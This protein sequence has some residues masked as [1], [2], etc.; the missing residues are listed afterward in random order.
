MT[1]FSNYSIQLSSIQPIAIFLLIA[2][3]VAWYLTVLQ[4]QMMGNM[5]GTMG[6]TLASYI[7]MWTLM[8]AAMML[9]SITPLATRYYR[10]IRS[11][12]L[13]GSLSFAAGY[14][15]IWA[16]TGILAFF[17]AWF[18]GKVL[19]LESAVQMFIAAAIFT[20]CGIYQFSN[21]KNTCLKVCRAPFSLLLKYASWRGPFRHFRVGLHHGI[22]CFSCCFFLMALMFVFGVMNIAAMLVLTIV[23]ALEKHI[24]EE[25]ILSSAVGIVC[26]LFAIAV[27]LMPELAPGLISNMNMIK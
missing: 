8:M 16:L 11:Y 20:A 22:F 18:A 21:L 5:A 3:G 17:S 23:I 26:F 27:F 19:I 24:A 6:M 9:P 12:K 7:L 10:M 4:S 2:S 13:F 1:K 15:V 25:K 14:L